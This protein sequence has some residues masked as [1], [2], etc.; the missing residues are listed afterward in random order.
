MSYY[1]P[2]F[3]GTDFDPNCINCNIGPD[4]EPDCDFLA[5]GKQWH[6][7][8]VGRWMACYD[9]SLI[10]THWLINGYVWECQD[11]GGQI[12]IDA[13]GY[14]WFDLLY[15]YMPYGYNWGEKTTVYQVFEYEVD[16]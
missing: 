12:V 2:P 6:Y 3:C 8:G 10:G 5:S 16:R 9:R 11:T 4:G 1:W 7:D 14:A 13:D 15:P